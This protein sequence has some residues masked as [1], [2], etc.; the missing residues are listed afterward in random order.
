MFGMQ[1]HSESPGEHRKAL[2]EA[3]YL[4]YAPAL[5]AFLLKQTSAREDA[6]DLLL[7]VFRAALEHTRFEQLSAE[8]QRLWLWRIARHKLIDA[9]RRTSRRPSVSVELMLNDLF[10]NE[11]Q[12]PEYAALRGEEFSRLHAALQTLPQLQQRILKLRFVNGLRSAE[13]ASLVG[14]SD[15]AV[16]SILSRTLNQLRTSYG[17]RG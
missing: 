15:T 14:K 16:R 7:E 9:Y 5:F 4:R 11:D 2:M 1:Q 17:E 13:I 6:E 8:E 3:L 10:A 12:A